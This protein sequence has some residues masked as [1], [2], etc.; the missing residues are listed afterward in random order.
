MVRCVPAHTE[1]MDVDFYTLER[2]VQDRFSDATRS[3]GLPTPILWEAPESH[4]G[5]YWL[6][7]AAVIMGGLGFS[8]LRGF[9]SLD[10]AL[11]IAPPALAAASGLAVAAASYCLLRALARRHARATIPYRPGLYLFPAGVFDARSDPIRVYLHPELQGASV[12]D[13]ARL[14]VAG[15]SGEFVF[16]LP[17]AETAEQA[18]EAF[19]RSRELYEQAAR[20]DHRRERAMLDPLVDSGFSSPFSPKQRLLRRKPL[21]ARLAL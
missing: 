7:A 5:G 11:A 12:V 8:L 10:S 9:G 16:R 4:S 3:I 14:K 21:W 6:L 20:S 15:K 2:P 13:G 19:G 18:R 1:A 17:N